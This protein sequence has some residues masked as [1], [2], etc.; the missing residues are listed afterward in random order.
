M[1]HIKNSSLYIGRNE[2]CVDK[3]S[4]CM[5]DV[6]FKL[7]KNKYKILSLRIRKYFCIVKVITQKLHT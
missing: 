2:I 4:M 3:I 5:V 1:K 6:D 7:K